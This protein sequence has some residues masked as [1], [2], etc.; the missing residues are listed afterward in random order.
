[1]DKLLKIT[2]S[3]ILVSFFLTGKASELLADSVPEE[4]KGVVLNGT[5]DKPIPMTT[6]TLYIERLNSEPEVFYSTTNNIGEFVFEN[7]EIKKD[8]LYWLSIFYE[9]IGYTELFDVI[10]ENKNLRLLV[11]DTTTS[12][13]SISIYNSSILF[14]AVDHLNR[15]ISIIEMVTLLNSSNLTYTPGSEPMELLRFG[16][17]ED[18]FNLMIDTEIPN[19]DWIQIDKGFAL[20]ASI[21]PGKH[22][23]MY[24]YKFPY[25]GSDTQF[26]KNWRYGSDNLRIVMPE[27]LFTINT[28]LT[29]DSK[30]LNLGGINYEVQETKDIERM[31]KMEV[32]ISNLPEPTIFEIIKEKFKTAEYIYV[33]P[34][35]LGLL[36]FI[37]VSIFIWKN[38]SRNKDKYQEFELIKQMTNNLNE[39][40]NQGKISEERYRKMIKL[41]EDKKKNT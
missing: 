2:F 3:I 24:A 6:I 7:I 20:L 16:L 12:D 38:K 15:E 28:N 27:N 5:T 33:A 35:S 8:S 32:F 41:L 31:R 23:L 30:I 10:S 40:F 21:V 37:F 14:S 13:E 39:E 19:A 34:I 17:P 1:L 4:I 9:G 25:S 22:E 11:Y 36:L 29:K 26:I 18:A